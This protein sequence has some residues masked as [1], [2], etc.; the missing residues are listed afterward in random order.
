MR[1]S[2]FIGTALIT[3]ASYYLGTVMHAQPAKASPGTFLHT[4]VVC[5]KNNGDSDSMQPIT[6]R[7]INV[8]VINS[9]DPINPASV[10]PHCDKGHTAH[11]GWVDFLYVSEVQK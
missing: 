4:G 9:G 11:D 1:K 7:T 10:T 3:I 6:G 5:A 8:Y 2:W